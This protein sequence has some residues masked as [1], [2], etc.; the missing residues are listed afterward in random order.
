MVIALDLRSI[1]TGSRHLALALPQFPL[2]SIDG[3]KPALSQ[4]EPDKMLGG[5][6]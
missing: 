3:Y 2:R 4:E 1:G 5:S 6:V